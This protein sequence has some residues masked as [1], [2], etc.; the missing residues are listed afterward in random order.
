MNIECNGCRGG[1]AV[2]MECQN[3]GG[4]DPYNPYTWHVV[5]CPV[6]KGKGYT[7]PADRADYT[8]ILND[9]HPYNVN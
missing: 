8:V 4:R 5:V 9:F 1:K 7:T 3:L 6:C 2:Y